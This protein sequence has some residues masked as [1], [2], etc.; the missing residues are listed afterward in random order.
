MQTPTAPTGTTST[1][2]LA[3]GNVVKLSLA[4]A[5]GNV[6]LTLQNPIIGLL[7]YLQVTQ[8]VSAR[9]L[10]FPTGTTQALT[11]GNVWT[12]TGASKL[13]IIPFYYDGTVFRIVGTVP[14]C[15]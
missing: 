4:S 11:V 3:L 8:G 1:I 14:D 5:S 7:C 6:T 2:D 13:D 9:T 15:A 10:T 12:S